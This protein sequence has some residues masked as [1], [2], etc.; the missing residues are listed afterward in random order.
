M[1]QESLKHLSSCELDPFTGQFTACAP[2]CEV[3]ISFSQSSLHSPRS[4]TNSGGGGGNWAV[5]LALVTFDLEKGHGIVS[6]LR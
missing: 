6:L 1:N 2:G 3:S 4:P 5:A